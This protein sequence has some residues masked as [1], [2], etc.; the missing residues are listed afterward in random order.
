[1]AVTDTFNPG[2]V[3][4]VHSGGFGRVIG[5]G[6]A[7]RGAGAEWTHA[8]LI[9]SS[10]GVTIEAGSSG[11]GYSSVANHPV[12]LV[13]PCPAGVI[14]RIVLAEA[15][16]FVGYKYNYGDLV[17]L[18]LDCL[19]GT[20]FHDSDSGQLICSELVARCL[21]AGGW[22]SPKR[23]SRMMPSDLFVALTKGTP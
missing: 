2:D 17:A 6:E 21:V 16:S 1:M 5:L 18:G 20:G 8:A 22:K 15:R 9:V 3:L 23:P 12:H 11:V 4:L 14:R 10:A 13:L 7:I 19:L